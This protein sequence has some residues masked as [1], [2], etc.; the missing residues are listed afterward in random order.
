M[1]QW[2]VLHVHCPRNRHDLKAA[3][4]QRHGMKELLH[5]AEPWSL[6]MLKNRDL[7]EKL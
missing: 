5:F 2:T 4:D 3:M 6:A 7:F 1:Q